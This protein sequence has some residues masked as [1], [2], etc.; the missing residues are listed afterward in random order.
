MLYSKVSYQHMRVSIQS[1]SDDIYVA[2]YTEQTKTSTI[3]R[4]VELFSP[5]HPTDIDYFEIKNTPKLD[6][7]G[8]V[9]DNFSFVRSD[10][11][12]K[13]QCEAVFFPKLTVDNSWILFCELKYSTKPLNN[14]SN[15]RKA[16][17]QLIK[18]RY[19]YIQDGIIDSTNLSYLI[20]SLPQQ[21]EPFTNFSISQT[22]LTKLKRK[23]SIILR[24]RNSVEI[25]DNKT[26]Q[27]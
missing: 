6:I 19:Y 15:L 12:P 22:F 8:I 11:S 27:V 14:S 18:T 5:S 10:G 2:D 26:I 7:E 4:S 13:S 17:K 25:I 9:F 24:M 21:S 16:I 20:A 3:K 1:F 23:R